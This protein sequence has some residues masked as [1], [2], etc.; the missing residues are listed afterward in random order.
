MQIVEVEPYVVTV[1]VPVVAVTVVVEV[2]VVSVRY[3][4]SYHAVS[5]QC[6]E[7][8]TCDSGGDAGC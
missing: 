6:Y 2:V 8:L 3:S 1:E 4:L 5:P 7:D